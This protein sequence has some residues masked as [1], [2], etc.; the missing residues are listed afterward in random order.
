MKVDTSQEFF[1][2]LKNVAEDCIETMMTKK[3]ILKNFNKAQLQGVL[4]DYVLYK[5]NKYPMIL[6]TLIKIDLS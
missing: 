2:D 3:G 1:D 5:I 6:V 4:K